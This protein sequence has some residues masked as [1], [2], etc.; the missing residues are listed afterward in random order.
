MTV[1]RVRKRPLRNSYAGTWGSGVPAWVRLLALAAALAA[2]DA[3]ADTRADEARRYTY[4]W[5]FTDDAA[6]RPRG[7]STQGP[8]VTLA[9][10]P[11]D[12]WGR[13]IE[14]GL[15]AFERDRRAILAM[16]GGYRTTFDFIET[17][18]F[19]PGYQPRPPYQS[20]ATEYIEV[21][22]DEPRF[23]S[24]QHILVM[25]FLQPD[26]SQ[27]EPMVVKHWRQ[28]WRYEDADLHAYQGQG[29]WQ[30][31]VLGDEQI[32]G[33]W[34]Q[35]VFQVDDSPRYQAVGRWRHNGNHATWTSELT[36]RPLPRR[37]S[38]VR[39]DYQVL[40]GTNRVTI[41]PRGWIHEE[42]NLKMVLESAG[43]PDAESPYL[44]REAG[45]N[46]YRRIVDY[47]FSAGEAYWRRTGPFWREVRLAWDDVFARHDRFS[48]R[49]EVDGQPQFQAMFELAEKFGDPETFDADATGARIEATLE[50]F[51][52]PAVATKPRL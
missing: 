51:I 52:E 4:S 1:H 21:I 29:R 5:Q 49:P 50:K 41:T 45:L 22:A 10:E 15:T 42:D 24:L 26:G 16:A 35:S 12:A 2:G 6:M 46:R 7:G 23:I 27:S 43:R 3:H 36:W 9:T 25:T 8:E 31:R 19:T 28:D 33:T 32:A 44:A 40:A 48:L 39:D 30:R 13:L 47:D 20:W 34:S 11:S 38:S 18:G 37:E 17:I 14:P